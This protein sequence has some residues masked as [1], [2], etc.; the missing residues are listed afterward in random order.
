LAD[1]QAEVNNES[2]DDDEDDDDND[3][4][5]D[6][7]DFADEW[8]IR[9]CSAA[10]I[11]MLS[12]VFGDD[13]L[14]DLLPPVNQMLS[15]PEWQVKEAGILALGAIAQGASSGMQQHLPQLVPHLITLL[16]HEKVP[17]FTSISSP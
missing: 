14:S 3:D 4:N 8:N 9:K 1:N 7:N 11:D 2:D 5:D 10:S 12:S 15:S 6:D 17:L 13:I 16:S